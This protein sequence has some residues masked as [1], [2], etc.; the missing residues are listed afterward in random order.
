M[1]EV[2]CYG[3]IRRFNSRQQ[4]I[5]FYKICQE[6]SEGAER[7]RYTNILCDLLWTTEKVVYDF[8]DEY[9]EYLSGY[10]K[11]SENYQ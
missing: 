10:R 5:N 8:E 11:L 7:E 6:N 4:A 1:V 9:L 3:K 2:F